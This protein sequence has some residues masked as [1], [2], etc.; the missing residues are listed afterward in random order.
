MDCEEK[1]RRMDKII[2]SH[3]KIIRRDINK[4]GDMDL[5]EK[6]AGWTE[7]VSRK[8]RW[9]QGKKEAQSQ[10]PRECYTKQATLLPMSLSKYE[11]LGQANA[12]GTKEKVY[13]QIRMKLDS[14]S[15]DHIVGPSTLKGV[16]TRPN[17]A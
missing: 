10:P 15:V 3:N 1:I 7:V 16:R 11:E 12:V 4:L 8:S 6:E 13:E 9:G 5:L 17:R 2:K 14:G